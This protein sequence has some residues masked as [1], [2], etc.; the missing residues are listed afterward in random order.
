MYFFHVVVVQVM[1]IIYIFSF[2]E[3]KGWSTT[4]LNHNVS[5]PEFVLLILRIHCWQAIKQILI[6]S[7]IAN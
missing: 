1:A 2:K 4:L 5:A 6:T 3:G 7:T